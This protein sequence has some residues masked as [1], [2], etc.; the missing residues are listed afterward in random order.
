MYSVI[1]I[2][3]E[4]AKGLLLKEFEKIM[5]VNFSECADE[6]EIKNGYC[7]YNISV[8]ANHKRHLEE[9]ENYLGNVFKHLNLFSDCKIVIDISIDSKDLAGRNMYSTLISSSLLRVLHQ[10]SADLE[11]TIYP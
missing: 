4:E 6:D 3:A 5:N 1:R 7:S 11:F 10:C 2:E 9:I 8:N